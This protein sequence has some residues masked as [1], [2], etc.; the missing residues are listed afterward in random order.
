M[1]IEADS[2]K[3]P[4]PAQVYLSRA[5]GSVKNYDGS[6]D[7]FKV[8]QS[9]LCKP[10]I[11]PRD[12][13]YDGWCMYGENVIEFQMPDVGGFIPPSRYCIC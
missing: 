11:V 7:W 3:H 4:G 6:G 8:H 5:D 12:L 13:Q 9:I 1:I 10:G 2:S